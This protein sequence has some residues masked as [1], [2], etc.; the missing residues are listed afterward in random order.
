V[1]LI[2][3]IIIILLNCKWGFTRWQ[4][5]YN[6]IQGFYLVLTIGSQMAVRSA[7]RTGCALLT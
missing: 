7:V 5:Y 3:I 4:W 6:K 2:I 1:L